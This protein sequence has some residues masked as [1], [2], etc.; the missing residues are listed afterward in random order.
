MRKIGLSDGAILQKMNLDGV[1]MD[2]L[3]YVLHL[4]INLVLFIYL[5]I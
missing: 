3:E 5:T 4:Y 2:L 1:R